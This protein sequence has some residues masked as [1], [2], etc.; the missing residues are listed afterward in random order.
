MVAKQENKACFLAFLE[1]LGGYF[2]SQQKNDR[3]SL[4]NYSSDLKIYKL[5]PEPCNLQYSS[6]HSKE[7]KQN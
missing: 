7:E 6:Y 5:I 4:W 2:T 3:Q 1:L